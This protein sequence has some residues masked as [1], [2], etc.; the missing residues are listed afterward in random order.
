MIMKG[1]EEKKKDVDLDV[2]LATLAQQ[3]A[4]SCAQRKSTEA[5]PGGGGGGGGGEGWSGTHCCTSCGGGVNG[6]RP[7]RSTP[8]TCRLSALRPH[9]HNHR[10]CLVFFH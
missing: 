6:A 10:R 4:G 5:I 2:D 3:A 9:R 7:Q 8:T 1:E